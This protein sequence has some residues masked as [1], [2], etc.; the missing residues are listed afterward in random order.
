MSSS[1]TGRAARLAG[2][3]ARRARAMPATE[4]IGGRVAGRL[5][6]SQ[7]AREVVS[8]VFDV[9]VTRVGQSVF[10]EAGRLVGGHGLD[11]LPVVLVSLIGAADEDVPAILERVAQ[12]QVLTAGFRPVILLDSDHFAEVR[13]YGWPVDFVVPENAWTAGGVSWHG[14][15]RGRLRSMRRAYGAVALVE[16]ADPESPGSDVLASMGA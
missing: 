16:L 8:R 11:R 3:L 14:Y 10:L 12:E 4:R 1:I 2:A 15:V 5:R 6:D 7:T 9:D 13:Q